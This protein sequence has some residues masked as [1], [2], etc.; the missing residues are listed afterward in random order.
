MWVLDKL[1]S[2][3]EIKDLAK[4][5]KSIWSEYKEDFKNNIRSMVDSFDQAEAPSS[6]VNE[7]VARS[8]KENST[9]ATFE[10][11]KMLQP[12]LPKQTK[13]LWNAVADKPVSWAWWLKE[14]RWRSPNG[15]PRVIPWSKLDRLQNRIQ[16]G[17]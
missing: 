13:N 11:L 4:R 14:G 17:L 7:T 12:T 3:K 5:M 9:P 2:K 8:K 16:E 15:V 6:T 10:K 1:F